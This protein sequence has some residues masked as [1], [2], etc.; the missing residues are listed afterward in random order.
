MPKSSLYGIPWVY[1][2]FYN[3]NVHLDDLQRRTGYNY[4]LQSFKIFYNLYCNKYYKL[5]GSRRSNI[6]ALYFTLLWDFMSVVRWWSLSSETCSYVKIK[7]NSGA[8]L[9]G[10]MPF[11][12]TFCRHNGISSIK[13]NCSCRCSVTYSYPHLHAPVALTSVKEPT[14]STRLEAGWIPEA[15]WTHRRRDKSLASA[16]NRIKILWTSSPW[17]IPRNV[18]NVYNIK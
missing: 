10:K 2:S 14:M 16:E 11:C 3:I 6:T 4:S 18:C 13:L 5:V 1:T 7:K 8:V 9:L 12:S 15:V 17:Q